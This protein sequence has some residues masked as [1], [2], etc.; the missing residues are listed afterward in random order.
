[1][2]FLH[3]KTTLAALL[4]TVGIPFAIGAEEVVGDPAKAE[5]IVARI[6]ADCHGM[7]GSSAAPNYPKL[8]GQHPE[9]LLRE[10]RAFKEGGRQNEA[11]APFITT[12]SEQ[13]MANLALYFAAQK[14]SP[15]DVTKPELQAAGKKLFFEGNPKSGVPACDGCHNSDGSGFDNYP[16]IAGQSV[17]YMLK[18]IKLFATHVRKSRKMR[19]NMVAERLTGQEAEAVTQYLASLK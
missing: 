13:D 14:P 17:T 11:M 18:Q 9:Y 3:F 6:C 12:L 5:P 1:M 15:G 19:M 16:R 7:H 2:N 10:L 8:A 4:F